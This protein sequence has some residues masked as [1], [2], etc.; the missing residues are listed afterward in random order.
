LRRSNRR[1]AKRARTELDGVIQD[2]RNRVLEYVVE[3]PLQ[4]T[5]ENV[6]NKIKKFRVNDAEVDLEVVCD[7]AADFGI[8]AGKIYTQ[9][10]RW[11]TASERLL[12]WGYGVF[13]WLMVQKESQLLQEPDV[14]S[15]Y[16]IKAEAVKSESSERQEN[17]MSFSES[18]GPRVP[19]I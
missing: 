11:V 17:V 16:P 8:I 7:S 2:A 4:L 1:G 5:W 13:Y 9:L 19:F 18:R 14:S 3:Q 15:N 10:M 12:Q 6:E